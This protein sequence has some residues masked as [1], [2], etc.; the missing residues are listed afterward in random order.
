MIILQGVKRKDGCKG[1]KNS[2]PDWL[3]GCGDHPYKSD[4]Y[5]HPEAA[6]SFNKMNADYKNMFR[7]KGI[8]INSAYRDIFHQGG[9][10]SDGKPKA[11]SGTS[12]HGFGLALDI[13][14]GLNWVKKNGGYYGW[15]WYGEKDEPHFN[16]F[17][18]LDEKG[19][20]YTCVS[21]NKKRQQFKEGPK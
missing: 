13:G 4:A 14:K 10:N 8:G 16:Y 19:L 5:L 15:C 6:Q 12:N 7:K 20:R 3:H 2:T 9:V 1:V 21:K 11:G 18:L 17:P